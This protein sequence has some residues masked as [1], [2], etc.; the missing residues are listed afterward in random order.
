MS[1]ILYLWLSGVLVIF[2]LYMAIKI[3][4]KNKIKKAKTFSE[5]TVS[6]ENKPTNEI[7]GKEKDT[8]EIKEVDK[9]SHNERREKSY[10]SYGNLIKSRKTHVVASFCMHVLIWNTCLQ[11]TILKRSSKITMSVEKNFY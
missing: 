9:T 2:C 5:I 1:D 6:L 3:H 11:S 10:T 7:H 4:K 8:I